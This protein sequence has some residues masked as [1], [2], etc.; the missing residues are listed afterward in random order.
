MTNAPHTPHTPNAEYLRL[1]T[2]FAR[3]LRA[4]DIDQA[5]WAADLRYIRI[6]G[7]GLRPI[8]ICNDNPCGALVGY[9]NGTTV[10]DDVLKK[11]RSAL[12]EVRTSQSDKPEARLQARLI[13]H[14]LR[15]PESLPGLLHLAQQCD[16]LHFITDELR[17]NDI[18]ADVVLL[19]KKDAVWFPVFIELKVTRDLK[20]LLKQLDNI[21]RYVG[22][23][24]ETKLAFCAFCKAAAGV[25]GG[26]DF[27]FDRRI[28][29]IIWPSLVDP[30]RARESTHELLASRHV[31]EFPGDFPYQQVPRMGLTF[32]QRAY[33]APSDDKPAP[34]VLAP[35]T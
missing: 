27:D 8:S 30:S 33:D 31:L 15:A 17:V 18:R 22:N 13:E 9:L 21:V 2:G 3:D 29:M 25:T 10:V 7:S 26:F 5:E 19:G 20:R 11:A 35:I 28:E 12:A 34:L 6:N 24:E 4:A 1:M 23:D 14:A 32:T 16:E